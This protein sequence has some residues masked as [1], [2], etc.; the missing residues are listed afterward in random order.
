MDPMDSPWILFNEFGSMFGYSRDHIRSKSDECM[1][2]VS[3]NN[4]MRK[5]FSS[6]SN[7]MKKRFLIA[8]SLFQNARNYLFDETFASIDPVGSALL[9]EIILNLRDQGF[10]ILLSSHILSELQ[11]ISDR[12]SIINSG[13]LTGTFNPEEMSGSVM[14]L[15]SRSNPA[16]VT[17]IL[18]RYGSVA[19]DGHVYTVRGDNITGIREQIM[20]SVGE[21]GIEV[22]SISFGTERLQ[23]IF[24][25]SMESDE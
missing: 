24:L 25:R 9:K 23:D 8:L 22:I 16:I 15:R 1:K 18:S 6:F 4:V 17:G 2:Q 5:S 12:V 14:T 11:D 20:K 13:K 3:L 7:G 19:K 10:S 21:S